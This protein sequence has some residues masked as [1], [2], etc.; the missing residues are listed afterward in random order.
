M[1]KEFSLAGAFSIAISLAPSHA[2]AYPIDCAILLCL[3]GGFPA[4]AECSAAKT[5]MMARLASIPPQPPLQLW[6]CPM[7]SGGVPVPGLG[8]DGLNADVRNIRDSIELYKVK[9]VKPTREPPIDSTQIGAYDAEGQFYWR[10][11]SYLEGP[12]WV[13]DLAGEIP[14]TMSW[15]KCGIAFRAPDYKGDY[16][17][18]WL[19][20]MGMR[21]Y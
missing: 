19:P 3:A 18:E 16:T 5:T 9:A 21:C 20:A 14:T 7:Q 8:T 17:V 12:Q 11:G 6:N 13:K 10:Q 2:N 1:L 15:R 4:S